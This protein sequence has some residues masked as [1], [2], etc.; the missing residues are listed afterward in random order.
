MGGT[1][2]FFGGEVCSLPHMCDACVGELS[3][4]M[5]ER[6]ELRTQECLLLHGEEV[7]YCCANRKKG[8]SVQFSG[9][10]WNEE[11]WREDRI[12]NLKVHVDTTYQYCAL[13]LNPAS[14]LFSLLD[15]KG[16]DLKIA[17]FCSTSCF[18]HRGYLNSSSCSKS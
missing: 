18:L 14:S 8:G 10:V 5:A 9:L 6:P 13:Q 1:S 2:S 15:D 16:I 4:I 7:M 11:R 3:T 17:R 12:L